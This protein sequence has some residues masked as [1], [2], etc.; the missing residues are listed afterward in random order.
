VS[1]GPPGPEAGKAHVLIGEPVAP[2]ISSGAPPSFLVGTAGSFSIETTTDAF[3]TP[4]LSASGAL[5]AGLTFVEDTDGTATLS[6]IPATGTGGTHSFSVTAA[7]GFGA[8]AT[9]PYTLTVNEAP[10]LSSPAAMRMEVGISSTLAITTS[11]AYPSSVTLSKS[12]ALP[13]GVTFTDNGDGTASLHGTPAVNSAGVYE[14]TVTASNGV[15]T[16]GTQTLRLRVDTPGASLFATSGCQSWTS[17]PGATRVVIDAVGAAGESYGIAPG[18]KGDRVAATVDGL[19]GATNFRVCVATGGGTGAFLFSPDDAN[20]GGGA[21]GVSVGTDFS[22]PLVVAGGGGS[23]TQ[24][25]AGGDAGL[26]A[27]EAGDGS[28]GGGGGTASTAGAGGI[29]SH[30]SGGP[31]AATDAS[32]PGQG[33]DGGQPS[34]DLGFRPGGAGGAGY[35]GGGAGGSSSNSGTPAWGAG[36][37]GSDFCATTA[38]SGLNVLPCDVTP[39]AGT[40]TGA[41]ENAG[42]AYVRLTPQW[43]PTI[44]SADSVS[45]NAG[46][47]CSFNVTT[48]GRGFPVASIAAAGNL[49]PGMTFTDNGDG[50]AKLSG[51]PSSAGTF[52]LTVTAANGVPDDDE[53][54][55]TVNVTGP[56]PTG[57]DPPPRQLLDAPLPTLAKKKL[58]PNANDKLKL[59]LACPTSAPVACTGALSVVANKLNV[60]KASYDVAPGGSQTLKK[61]ASKKVLRALA[62]KR[63]IKCVASVAATA[64]GTF[65]ASATT[66][67]V[68]LKR[69]RTNGS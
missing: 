63:K 22:Q 46:E 41:G 12:G 7:N 47:A 40:S 44:T 8:G 64:S 17:P 43:A 61:K 9:V 53:Q 33:G 55:L 45:C 18:G 13:P 6:G 28:A 42:E 66:Y 30:A 52:P 1:A 25:S 69:G 67:A 57:G 29:G 48:P 34:F 51:I 39:G 27:G 5:P 35:F 10:R 62:D 11:H 26:P 36:G 31:G 54:T 14:L 19:T 58:R 16:N 50:T 3:P 24:S 15:G 60:F 65:G 37:G 4:V 2:A 32:G 49:P 20:H 21:S 68:T 59:T 23:A 38:V 56:P